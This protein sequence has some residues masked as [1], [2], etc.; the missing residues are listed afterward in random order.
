MR[1]SEIDMSLL[2][3]V[4]LCGGGRAIGAAPGASEEQ[5]C[6]GLRCSGDGPGKGAEQCHTIDATQH[7]SGKGAALLNLNLAGA[8][9]TACHGATVW[10]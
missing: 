9:S 6:A 1:R 8:L 2:W 7:A 3:Q 4:P 5:E 10:P